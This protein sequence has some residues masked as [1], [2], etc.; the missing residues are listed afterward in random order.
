MEKTQ[1]IRHEHLKKIRCKTIYEVHTDRRPCSKDMHKQLNYWL[2][3]KHWIS[4][5]CSISFMSPAIHIKSIALRHALTLFPRG[6]RLMYHFDLETSTRPE[7]MHAY[8]VTRCP[9]SS[10]VFSWFRSGAG[11]LVKRCDWLHCYGCLWQHSKFRCALC[12]GKCGCASLLGDTSCSPAS[13]VSDHD[14]NVF[15]W[16]REVAKPLNANPESC[17][18]SSPWCMHLPNENYVS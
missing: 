16:Q 8:T 14:I 6:A 5:R 9:L 2:T 3:N 10:D 18:Y 13:S 7:I 11:C 4:S 17:E 1:E 15:A 12:S